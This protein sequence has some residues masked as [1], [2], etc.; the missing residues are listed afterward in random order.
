MGPASDFFRILVVE[1]I[2][3]FLLKRVLSNVPN[4]LE[5]KRAKR[6]ARYFY[7]AHDISLGAYFY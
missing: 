7:A 1:T 5:H 2:N 6:I 4:S 3:I